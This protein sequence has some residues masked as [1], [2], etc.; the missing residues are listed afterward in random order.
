MKTFSFLFLFLLTSYAKLVAQ[1]NIV[2]T[3]SIAEKVILSNYDPVV[4]TASIINNYRDSISAGINARVSPDSLHAYIEA[5][6]Y[7]YNRNTGSDTVS[8]TNGIGAAR[9]WAFS[10]F[11]QF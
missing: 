3:D 7:I 10:K 1:S 11:L 8:S 5:L 4:Y 9:R 6:R 2:C